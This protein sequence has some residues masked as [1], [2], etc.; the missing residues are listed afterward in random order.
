MN[1]SAILWNAY[2]NKKM[3]HV[4]LTFFSNWF[5][6]QCFEPGRGGCC[7]FFF[8]FSECF[9]LRSA[10]TAEMFQMFSPLSGHAS[11]RCSGARRASQPIISLAEGVML[12]NVS[13]KTH[14][15]TFCP[16]TWQVWLSSLHNVKYENQD[17]VLTRGVTWRWGG[18]HELSSADEKG[19]SLSI[20]L[21]PTKQ[22]RNHFAHSSQPSDNTRC[23]HC[24]LRCSLLRKLF[25]VIL[26]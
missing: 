12:V 19:S 26:Q 25:S 5:Q 17:L 9:L 24:T 11:S 7:F 20:K 13:D 3:F 23:G 21:P 4:N 18:D 14:K 15:F 6:I 16:P 2:L 22:K 1:S 10:R 8:F